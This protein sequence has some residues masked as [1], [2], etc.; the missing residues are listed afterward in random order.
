MS[1]QET[2]LKAIADAIRAK[3][4]TTD[5][6][7]ASQFAAKIGEIS[8]GVAKPSWA[9]STLPNLDNVSAEWTSV[10]YGNGKFVAVAT[11]NSA[12]AY[13]TDGINW[14]EAP[15]TGVKLWQ[16][17]CYGDGK[18][19]AVALN[20]SVAAYST[21]GV[22][23]TETTMPGERSWQ[24]VCYGDGKFVAVAN[25]T[26]FGAYSTDGIAWSSMRMLTDADMWWRVCYGNGKFVAITQGGLAAAVAYSTDGINW[27]QS[28]AAGHGINT[29]S[30][31][32]G[33]DKFVIM[34]SSDGKYLY[35][36][37][38]ISWTTET[39]SGVDIWVSVGYGGDK[40]VA[41]PIN[42]NHIAYSTDGVTWVWT[43]FTSPSPLVV[44]QTCFNSICYGNGIFVAIG[45]YSDADYNNQP[46]AAYLKDSFDEWA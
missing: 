26:Q 45:S 24:S 13:S 22:N 29:Q 4:G 3:L 37:D 34:F 11:N 17:V 25:D 2:N 15:M 43:P 35:S 9:Q 14:T 40:F 32:Y 7:K 8:T 30:I 21:D 42:G 12:A 38:G 6:I 33:R 46:I 44:D 23:W 27:T 16:S 41:M 19:V 1:I 10:C 20:S 39:Q 31:C 28:L 36:S 5:T 18:F